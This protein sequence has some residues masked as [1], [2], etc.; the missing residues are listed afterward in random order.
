[1]RKVSDKLAEKIKTHFLYSVMFLRKSCRLWVEKY[2]RDRQ[3]KDDSTIR[4]MR[5]AGWI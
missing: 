5:S 1:V 2:R 3:A 4:S